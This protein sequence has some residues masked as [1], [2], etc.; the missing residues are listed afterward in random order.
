MVS[1]F[2]KVGFFLFVVGFI[3]PFLVIVFQ[4]P[5]PFV[6]STHGRS[7]EA[8]AIPSNGTSVDILLANN[9]WN[10][11]NILLTTK[12]SCS[13]ENGESS[14]RI[15]ILYSSKNR[16]GQ[17]PYTSYTMYLT[18]GETEEVSRTVMLNAAGASETF[19]L[20]LR[21]SV[22]PNN[23]PS[24]DTGDVYLQHREVQALYMLF[25]SLIPLLMVIAGLAVGIGG[26]IYN[27]R[28]LAKGVRPVDVS[29]E[30][31]LQASRDVSPVKSKAPKMAIK[32]TPSQKKVKKKVVEKVVPKGGPQQA[33]KFCGKQVSA[34][35]FFCPHCYGKI[36]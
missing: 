35:A 30:P 7:S 6:F 29:W 33:C 20:Y 23:D 3:T 19:D 5:I 10:P 36:R 16:F 22:I 25:A 13:C 14:V 31:T 2:T 26:F 24:A 11:Y 32:A 1:N 15:L 8:V 34:A 28:R 18:D 21:I 4:L 17:L 12:Y 9:L 27:Y